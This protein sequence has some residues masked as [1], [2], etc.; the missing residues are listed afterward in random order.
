[1]KGLPLKPALF[2]VKKIGLPSNIKINNIIIILRGKVNKRTNIAKKKSKYDL[3]NKYK[4]TLRKT[5]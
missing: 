4:L 3:R 1:M 2:W 5:S